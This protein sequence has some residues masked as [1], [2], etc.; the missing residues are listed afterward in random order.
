MK[1][2]VIEC[3]TNWAGMGDETHVLIPDDMALD[4]ERLEQYARQLAIENGESYDLTKF[5][6]EDLFEG[7]GEDDYTEDQWDEASRRME[8]YIDYGITAFDEEEDPDE[9]SWETFK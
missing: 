2:V 8:E 1:K 3:S 5:V 4:D 6:A 7:D 9:Y